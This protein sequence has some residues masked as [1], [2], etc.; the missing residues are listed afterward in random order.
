M[1]LPII[2]LAVG[3]FLLMTIVSIVFFEYSSLRQDAVH[4]SISSRARDLSIGG[5]GFLLMMLLVVPG[6]GLGYWA[7]SGKQTSVGQAVQHPMHS[8]RDWD[9]RKRDQS[10]EM[11]PI[12]KMAEKLIDVIVRETGELPVKIPIERDHNDARPVWLQLED[13]QQATTISDLAEH[14]ADFHPYDSE[15]LT[16][17]HSGFYTTP[18]EA[19]QEAYLAASRSFQKAL[20]AEFNYHEPWALPENIVREVAV[21]DSYLESELHDFGS[22]QAEMYRL[23]LLVDQSPQVQAE[24]APWLQRII[25]G[26]RLFKWG[27]LF[28][29]GFVCLCISTLVL[30]LINRKHQM[31]S[32]S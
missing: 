23:H 26:L 29:V 22:A 27:A 25:V 21:R 30:K 1:A 20:N 14:N 28:A 32:V 13:K 2:F 9:D 17:I 7:V 8:R 12:D 10:V 6:Y 18:E 3:V 4:E 24:L 16:V 5:W 31:E 15:N 11:D 19:R